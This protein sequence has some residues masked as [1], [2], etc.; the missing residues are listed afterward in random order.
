MCNNYNKKNAF[1]QIA[2]LLLYGKVQAHG[3]IGRKLK[4]MS[5]ERFEFISRGILL[6]FIYTN[7]STLL[8]K[9]Y[10]EFSQ[11][12]TERMKKEDQWINCQNA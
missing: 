2:A 5:R 4:I 10:L 11:K 7:L 9:V 12:S 1:C 6:Y 3:G 8:K